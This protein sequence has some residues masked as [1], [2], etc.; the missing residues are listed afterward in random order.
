[1]PGASPPLV[2]TPIVFNL[3]NLYNATAQGR[4]SDPLAAIER[5]L[6]TWRKEAGSPYY[7]VL[8]HWAEKPPV[9]LVPQYVGWAL[10]IGVGLLAVAGGM[11]LLLRSQVQA[12]TRHLAE[13]N[14]AQRESEQR[15]QLLSTVASDYMFSTRIGAAGRLHRHWAA[16]AFVAIPGLTL[17]E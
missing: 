14:T 8:S 13:V 7:T 9:Y 16:G 12:R 6:S 11:I 2:N 15:Y 1:M 4:N 17:A 5:W 10:G 3:V